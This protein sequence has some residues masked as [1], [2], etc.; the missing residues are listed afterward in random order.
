MLGEWELLK[1]TSN[2]N[3]GFFFKNSYQHGLNVKVKGKVFIIM[4]QYIHKYT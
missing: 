1:I 3:I 4:W 2:V